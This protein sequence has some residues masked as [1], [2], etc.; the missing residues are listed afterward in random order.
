LVGV[1]GLVLAVIH[2]E[3]L[4]PVDRVA[5]TV[6]FVANLL[7]T[8]FKCSN[9]V[10]HERILNLESEGLIARTGESLK[11]RAEPPTV[12][13]LLLSLV[14]PCLEGLWITLNGAR[15]LGPKSENLHMLAHDIMKMAKSMLASKEILSVEGA[16]LDTVKTYLRAIYLNRLVD[17]GNFCPKPEMDRAIARVAKLRATAWENT[18]SDVAQGRI[19]NAQHS[20]SARL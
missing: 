19:F 3:R 2:T 14:H 5:N 17:E 11:L 18:A 7:G 1:D 10:V 15:S 4:V 16:T 12:T 9:L 13:L 8:P 6:G 20:E